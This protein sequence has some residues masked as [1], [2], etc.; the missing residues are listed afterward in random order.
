MAI[1]LVL[2]RLLVVFCSQV[3]LDM[4]IGPVKAAEALLAGLHA[5]DKTAKLR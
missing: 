2:G 5:R 4:R 3:G 1:S